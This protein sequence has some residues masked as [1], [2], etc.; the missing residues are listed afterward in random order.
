[1]F[2]LKIFLIL[3]VFT[4]GTCTKLDAPLNGRKLGK[5]H[6]VGHEVHFLCD[7]GFELMGSESRICQESLTWSGQQPTC[8]GENPAPIFS[9]LTSLWWRRS[10]LP[11]LLPPGCFLFFTLTALILLSVPLINPTTLSSS[12]LYPALLVLS[13]AIHL[14]CIM[15][16]TALF[17]V[18]IH[19]ISDLWSYFLFIN[20]DCCPER[21]LNAVTW[22][23]QSS[24]SSDRAFQHLSCT[25]SDVNRSTLSLF[26]QS[27]YTPHISLLNL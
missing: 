11:H 21:L 10:P 1:M 23:M 3:L 14:F 6:S 17:Y 9:Y 24:L 15:H 27:T 4:T 19:F 20:I 13:L 2:D 5:S 8:R 26:T 25:W 18:Q 22:D 12:S 7:P 16:V